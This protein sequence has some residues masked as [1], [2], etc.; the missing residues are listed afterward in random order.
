MPSLHKRSGVEWTK[1]DWRSSVLMRRLLLFMLSIFQI[2]IYVWGFKVEISN[3]TWFTT[4]RVALTGIHEKFLVK[5]LTYH[6][7]LWRAWAP[8]T[9]EC[10]IIVLFVMMCLLFKTT[11]PLASHFWDSHFTLGHF[12]LPER[13][14][15]M[16]SLEST[17]NSWTRNWI[18]CS[19][20]GTKGASSWELELR[21]QT[22][23]VREFNIAIWQ[24]FI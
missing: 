10:P 17:L 7:G 5:I 3:S 14:L 11:F 1:H 4:S 2:S 12:E 9:N 19:T 13:E 18:S 15:W 23:K 21:S 22:C 6:L 8:Q 16:K 24:A 20:Y